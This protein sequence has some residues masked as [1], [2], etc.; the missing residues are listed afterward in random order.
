MQPLN[1]WVSDSKLAENP[2]HDR[3]YWRPWRFTELETNRPV[4]RDHISWQRAQLGTT[5]V[6]ET[7]H[8]HFSS[9]SPLLHVLLD[10]FRKDHFSVFSCDRTKIFF[11]LKKNFPFLST[12]KMILPH[13]IT[14]EL[15]HLYHTSYF[16]ATAT[17]FYET[18]SS[19][20]VKR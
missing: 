3:I 19:S 14:N 7:D 17:F 5:L 2:S 11:L 9:S 6:A 12:G 16:W 4:A 10:H 20:L 15:G 18:F 1:Y 13:F 8:T